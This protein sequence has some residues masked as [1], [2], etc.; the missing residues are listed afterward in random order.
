MATR[1]YVSAVRSAAAD[2]KREHAV[3]TA[4]ELLRREPISAFSLEAVA[5][6]AGVTRLTLYNQFGS[7]RGLLEAAFDHIAARGQ[8]GRIPT[9]MADPSPRQG[10]EALVEIFCDFWGGDLA[11]QG[12][13]D[14]MTTDPEFA[15]ALGARNDRRR[16]TL[17]TLVER[18]APGDAASARRAQ[19]VDLLFALTSYPMYRLLRDGPSGTDP[20]RLV[21]QAC[22]D[23]LDRL[24][25]E[26]AGPS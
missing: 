23:A 13:H 5:R 6:A 16:R 22:D 24:E 19:T 8:L 4:V 21:Q 12:L 14:A 18:L 11:V 1:P 9:A 25:R 3:A 20:R 10:L 17:A 2:A 15:Q 7:R 26:A